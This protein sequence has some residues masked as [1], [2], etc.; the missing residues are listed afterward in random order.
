MSIP[1]PVLHTERLRLEPLAESHAKALLAYE[2]RNHAHLSPWE[3]A[4]SAEYFT[5]A[6]QESAIERSVGAPATGLNA[7]YLA[8]ATGSDAII[9]ATEA[10]RAIIDYAF[11]TLNLHRIETSCQPSNEAS[12]RVLRKLGF[13]VEGYARDHRFYNG[14]WRDNILVGLTNPAW[15]PEDAAPTLHS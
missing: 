15:R 9:A 5:L 7:R 3:P 13:I 1:R 11:G 12:G 4:R 10:A 6:Y 14:A 2:V 8:F